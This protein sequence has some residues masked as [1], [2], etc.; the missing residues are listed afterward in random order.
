MRVPIS[1]RIAKRTYR[2]IFLVQNHDYWMSCPHEYD[3]DKDLVLTFDFA[4]ANLVRTAGGEAQYLD[5][6]VNADMLEEYNYKTYDFLSSWHYNDAKQDIFTYREIE[7]GSAFRIEIW[8]DITYF[9]RIFINLHELF[10]QIKFES[11]FVCMEDPVVKSIV[12]SMNIKVQKWVCVPDKNT[13][14]YYFPVFKWME[15]SLHPKRMKYKIRV[16]VLRI[17]DYLA[18]MMD[19]LRR[20][21]RKK[22]V[23]I[24]R[25]HP[26]KDIIRT[27]NKQMKIRTVLRDFYSFSDLCSAEH[28]PVFASHLSKEHDSKAEELLKKFNDQKCAKL[29]ID[30][31]DISKELYALILKKIGP[32]LTRCFKIVDTIKRFFSHR[33]LSLM[34]TFSSIGLIN[35]L[36]INYCK[37]KSIPVY[38]IIN[39]L[40]LNSF[41]DEAKDGK[42]IN[43]YGESIKN[44]YFKGMNNIVCLGDPRMDKYSVN[45]RKRQTDYAKPTILIG[46]SGFTNVYLNCYLAIEFEFLNDIMKAC[47]I[48]KEKGKEMDLII[49]VRP[50]GYIEQYKSFIAEYYPEMPVSILG[51][52]P[53]DLLF[54]K[55]DF[56]ITLYSQ[57]LF[58][59]SY[60]G[61]PVLY[62]KNDTQYLHPPFDGK[63]ELVTAYS[64]DDLL[65]KIEA[66][67]NHDS[68]YDAFLDRGV[69][70][71]YIGPLDGMNLKRNMDFIYSLL[72]KN[73]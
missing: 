51:N 67:Y 53:L 5:H 31:I 25:Y 26:T 13:V 39:G 49:K 27:L 34:V 52:T 29:Y 48:L 12:I 35:R 59:A 17:L 11:I 70:E 44:N 68:I 64:P 14:E 47:N 15:E 69:M 36:M 9:V 28:L 57:V 71:Q 10:K 54:E 21:I 56:L 18:I 43:S 46:A 37:E 60:H 3:K 30:E 20:E 40:L 42:W 7:V 2:S 63:S 22:Y 45:R 33:Q 61:I 55:V 4:V 19:T 1:M 32:L 72:D 16:F 38:M 23:Y 73:V 66:F 8:N 24:E 50:N 62:Y 41:L 6:I 58:E 65:Q